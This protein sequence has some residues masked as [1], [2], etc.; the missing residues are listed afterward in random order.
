LCNKPVFTRGGQLL[1]FPD[2][3]DPEAGVVGEYGG[4]DHK[5]TDRRKSDRRREDRFL[6]HAL[7]Y[8]EV[9]T[10]ELADRPAVVR[11]MRRARESARYVSEED[12]SWTLTPPPGWVPPTWFRAA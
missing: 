1:G 7:T 11:R 12:R 8:F 6:E 3:F 5:R 9:V 10:G 4:S 2:L